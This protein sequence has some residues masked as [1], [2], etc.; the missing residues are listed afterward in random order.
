MIENNQSRY[1]LLDTLRKL[2]RARFL[3]GR[4]FSS[5]I[6]AGAQRLPLAAVFPRACCELRPWTRPRLASASSG[7]SRKRD[8]SSLRSLDCMTKSGSESLAS[9]VESP[10]PRLGRKEP[11]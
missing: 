3:G 11:R 5:D 6:K 1:A 4:S 10:R 2:A 7:T 9:R 8:S